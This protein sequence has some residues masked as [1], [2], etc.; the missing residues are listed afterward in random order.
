VSA[1]RRVAAHNQNV[2]VRKEALKVTPLHLE[3]SELPVSQHRAT[4]SAPLGRD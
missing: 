1:V 3:A 4:L 2:A